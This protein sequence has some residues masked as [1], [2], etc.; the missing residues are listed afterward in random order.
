MFIRKDQENLLEPNNRKTRAWS[1]GRQVCGLFHVVP[2]SSVTQRLPRVGGAA[3]LDA[4]TCAAA[5]P[6]IELTQQTI[7]CLGCPFHSGLASPG[8]PLLPSPGQRRVPRE[9]HNRNR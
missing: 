5:Q 8:G 2:G 4:K 9:K 6:K 7:D 3:Q 1:R